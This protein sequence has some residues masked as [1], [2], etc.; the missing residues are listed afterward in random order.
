MYV[1]QAVANILTRVGSATTVLLTARLAIVTETGTTSQQDIAVGVSQPSPPPITNF[2]ST[3]LP[4]VTVGHGFRLVQVIITLL[5]Y[6][7]AHM[8]TMTAISRITL[9]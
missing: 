7:L 2:N 3:T 8:L 9:T 5:T 4:V 6:H 1:T